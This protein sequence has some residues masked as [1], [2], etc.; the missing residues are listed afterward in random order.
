MLMSSFC[1]TVLLLFDGTKPSYY[2]GL[3]LLPL[4]FAMVICVFS[5]LFQLIPSNLGLT[6]IVFLFFIRTVVSPC[7]MLFG[8]YEG[9][10]T[11]GISNNTT[12]A[13][14][15]VCYETLCV[16]FTLYI[17][18]KK[19]N[20]GSQKL[21]EERRS[22]RPKTKRAY[23]WALVIVLAVDAACYY[24]AP[25]LL[26]GY[27]TI[28]QISDEY[29]TAYE[30]SYLVDKYATS[31]LLKLALVTGQYLNRVLLIIIPSALLVWVARKRN[32]TRRLIGLFI[33]L[34]PLMFI[35]GAIARSLIY[36]VCLLYFHNY[37]FEEKNSR[38][39]FF[40]LILGGITVIAWWVY[41]GGSSGGAALF[42][43]RFSSYF[44]GVNVVSGVFNMQRDISL[45]FKYFTLDYLGSIPFGTTLFSLT[46]ERIQPFFNQWNSSYGQIPTTIGM[47][48]YYFGYIFAPLYSIA[49]SY[50]SFNVGERLK[51]RLYNNPMQYM[52]LLLMAFYFSMGI[53]MYNIEITLG[54]FFGMFLPMYILERIAYR[55][56]ARNS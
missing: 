23:G 40:V 29:F 38:K 7:A 8:N 21:I 45:R 16:F 31:F 5:E 14:F 15:L 44:S 11:K 13:V 3:F 54:N 48:Y 12:P 20:L 41:R 1:T 2:A 42:S 25:M 46:G 10:I 19:V 55:K 37:I 30:D 51:Q 47:G 4:A 56:E 53:V 9:T 28:F 50:I 34:I 17:S 39:T 18:S 24:V 43:K 32:K 27:R 35:G 26:Q 22:M 6:L 33:C 52:R 36:I 49:F